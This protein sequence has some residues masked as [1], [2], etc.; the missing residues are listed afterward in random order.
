MLKFTPKEQ[1]N[2]D[3]IEPGSF[4]LNTHSHGVY[5]IAIADIGYESEG[6]P[7]YLLINLTTGGRWSSPKPLQIIKDM[8]INGGWRILGDVEIKQL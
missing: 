5:Y 1:E 8:I 2:A 6:R 3:K 4:V 7:T